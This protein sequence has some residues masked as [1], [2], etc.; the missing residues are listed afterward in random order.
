VTVIHSAKGAW[1]IIPSCA[2]PLT[3]VRRIG[4]G[5]MNA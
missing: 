2:L 4:L 5:L 1:K 3:S